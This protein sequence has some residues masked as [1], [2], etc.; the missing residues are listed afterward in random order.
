MTLSSASLRFSPDVSP[1]HGDVVLLHVL[2]FVT[3][4]AETC[5]AECLDEGEWRA[6]HSGQVFGFGRREKVLMGWTPINAQ[7]SSKYADRRG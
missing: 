7:Q 4:K 2:D 3:G 1:D 5:E 6:I